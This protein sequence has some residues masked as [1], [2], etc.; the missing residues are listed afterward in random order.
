MYL[1][2]VIKPNISPCLFLWLAEGGD[3]ILTLFVLWSCVFITVYVV[4]PVWLSV[5][6]ICLYVFLS[7]CLPVIYVCPSDSLSL[8]LIVCL[9]DCVSHC[10]SV[11]LPAYHP[12]LSVCLSVPLF[13]SVSHCLTACLPVNHIFCPPVPL[14][15]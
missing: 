2:N 1:E 11:C 14:S 3:W 5:L 7:H 13:V 12:C 6:S 10:L 8:C 9:S 15:V 4:C